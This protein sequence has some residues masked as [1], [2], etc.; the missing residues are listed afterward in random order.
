MDILSPP[1]HQNRT[2]ERPLTLASKA[3]EIYQRAV[4]R[5]IGR[6]DLADLMKLY[7]RAGE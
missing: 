7:D 3:V 2:L 1:M 4:H 6:N 5:G